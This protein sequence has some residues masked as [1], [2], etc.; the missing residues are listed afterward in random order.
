MHTRREETEMTKLLRDHYK[1]HSHL[2]EAA[3][4]TEYEKQRI[5]EQR[6]KVQVPRHMIV[7]EQGRLL[8]Y[9]TF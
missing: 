5:E 7:D 8:P 9:A 2:L 1:D 3:L 6:A 4:K